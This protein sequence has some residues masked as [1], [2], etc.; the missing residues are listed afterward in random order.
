MAHDV[1]LVHA[2]GTLT[3]S[4]NA[5][6]GETVVIG[7]KTYTFQTTLT[8][9]DGNVQLGAAASSSITNLV[10]AIN[11]DSGAG[12]AYAAA[13]TRNEKVWARKMSITEMKVSAGIG[14]SIGNHIPTT[15]TLGSGSWGGTTLAGGSG[16]ILGYLEGVLRWTNF[17]AEA[18]AEFHH[19]LPNL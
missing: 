19:L 12:T 8:N 16:S 1:T 11:L 4:G 6:N 17:N 7:G 10:A 2:E 13:M 9:V 14:G 15:T 18:A 3:F 5:A